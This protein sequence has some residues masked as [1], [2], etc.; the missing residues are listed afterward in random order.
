MIQRQRSRRRP[1]VLRS[2]LTMV[3]RRSMECIK[4]SC[5]SSLTI[6]IWWRS[7]RR[8]SVN[9]V[10]LILRWRKRSLVSGWMPASPEQGKDHECPLLS[11]DITSDPSGDFIGFPTRNHRWS[12]SGKFNGTIVIVQWLHFK[13][14]SSGQQSFEH[15]FFDLSMSFSWI[16]IIRRK[17]INK[18]FFLLLDN[19]LIKFQPVMSCCKVFTLLLL[20]WFV[21]N[22]NQSEMD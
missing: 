20:I 13:T 19:Y 3:R 11:L 18:T 1:L 9:A 22:T 15:A 10:P 8:R 17:K 16:W 2:R 21:Q 14:S 5:W 6:P 4:M 12:F 7:S